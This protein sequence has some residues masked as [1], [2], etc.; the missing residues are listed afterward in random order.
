MLYPAFGD[1][2][3]DEQYLPGFG[4]KQPRYDFGI[5]ALKLIIEVKVLRVPGDFKE[6]EEQIAGDT[7]LYFSD[8]ARFDKMVV[9]I[10]DD[11][12]AHQPERYASL[13]AAILQRDARVRAVV[14]VRRPGMMPD[15]NQRKPA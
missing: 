3:R 9:Y 15:R 6:V 13:R 1:Q 8:P 10:Y 2:L 14:I 5:I 4:L 7:G 11:C 12:D